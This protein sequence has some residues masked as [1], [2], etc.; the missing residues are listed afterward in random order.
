[1][2]RLSLLLLVAIAAVGG[3]AAAASQHRAPIYAVNSKYVQGVGP[4]Y[5]PQA[6][7]RA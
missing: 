6:G 4:G 5:W 7:E 2:K 1:M 3:R